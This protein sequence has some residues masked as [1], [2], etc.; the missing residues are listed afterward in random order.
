MLADTDPEVLVQG[1][2]HCGMDLALL[3]PEGR[4]GVGA[5]EP[6]DDVHPTKE[7]K[8]LDETG[9]DPDGHR[10]RDDATEPEDLPEARRPRR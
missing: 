1:A 5:G 9:E 3:R 10:Q 7:A 6:G 4:V 2:E 8:H